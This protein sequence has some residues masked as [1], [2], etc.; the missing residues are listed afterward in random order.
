MRKSYAPFLIPG[1]LLSLAV[2]GAPFVMNI[3]FSFTKW[4]GVTSPKWTGFDNYDKLVQDDAFWSSFEHN[5]GILVAMAIAPTILGLILAYAL[6]DFISRRFGP[7]TAS[8]IRAC[9]YLPQVLPIA[10]V[11]VVWSWI[12][13]PDDGALDKALG[14]VGLKSLGQDWLGDPKIALY[15]IMGVMIWFQIG[16]PLVI[17]MAGLQRVDPSLYE[18]ADLDGASWIRKFWNITVPQIRPEIFV[19][20]LTCSIA[21][22]KVFAPIF[23]L[24]RGGPG[25]ATNVPAYFSYQE[26]FEKTNVGY[27]SAIATTL[28]LLILVLTA[29][30]LVVQRRGE[31][32]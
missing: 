20:L 5:V 19:V 23:V 31:D 3:Y 18:A 15:S 16:Y 14:S 8:V 10:V 25:G 17:F 28:T 7:R 13:K 2:I 21:S 30:F 29:G 9:V 12:L 4:D 22:L 26:F 6:F 32:A 27:G 11:G 1:A 24:T